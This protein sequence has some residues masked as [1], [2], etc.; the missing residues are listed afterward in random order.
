MLESEFSNE[1]EYSFKF[2][3]IKIQDHEYFMVSRLQIGFRNLKV[4]YEIM[5]NMDAS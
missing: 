5:L 3:H 4:E 1:E 2:G